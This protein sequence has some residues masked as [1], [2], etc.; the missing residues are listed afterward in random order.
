MAALA[1]T[2]AHA[3]RYLGELSADVRAAVVLEPDGSLAASHPDERGIGEPM[4][5]LALALLEG[6]NRAEAGDDPPA[7]VE[8]ST[9]AGAVFVVREGGGRALAVVAERLALSSLM[10]YDL[11]RILTDLAEGTA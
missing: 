3:L 6:A 1:L 7:E 11:R 2:P 5:E 10:R 4:R 9:P 8:V